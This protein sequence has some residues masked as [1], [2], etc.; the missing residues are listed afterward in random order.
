MDYAL[1]TLSDIF[2]STLMANNVAFMFTNVSSPINWNFCQETVPSILR[3][4]PQYEID[5]P[6]AL[7]QKYLK[8]K[9]NPKMK[10]KAT[11][12]LEEV[13]SGELNAL[14]M[15]VGLFDW[16]DGLQPQRITA[17][18]TRGSL[19]QVIGFLKDAKEKL[20]NGDWKVRGTLMGESRRTLASVSLP[21]CL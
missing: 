5:N 4:A 17:E 12:L 7:Q 18:Q 10:H 6:F 15:L 11:K 20:G 19:A 3:D 14:G 9:D 1:S 2:P 13:K 21:F 8:L 16:L